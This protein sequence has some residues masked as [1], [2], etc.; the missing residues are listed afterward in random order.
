MG[1]DVVMSIYVYIYK[2]LKDVGLVK[3]EK[4]KKDKNCD[5][6][7][8]LK[9]FTLLLQLARDLSQREIVKSYFHA[10]TKAKNPW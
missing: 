10:S 5:R 3:R 9:N 4:Q 6:V 2:Y 7:A 1:W 8:A